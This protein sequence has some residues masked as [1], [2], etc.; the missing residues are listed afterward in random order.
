MKAYR[1][2]HRPISAYRRY[3]ASRIV[4]VFAAAMCLAQAVSA[5]HFHA[6]DDVDQTCVLC[7][8]RAVR[9]DADDVLQQ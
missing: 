7:R 8:L 9:A 6:P 3:A 1:T 5:Q 2:N 4:T